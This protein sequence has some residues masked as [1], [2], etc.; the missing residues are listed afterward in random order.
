MSTMCK[1]PSQSTYNILIITGNAAAKAMEPELAEL[2]QL[3][4]HQREA[5]GL[6]G[7]EQQTTNELSIVMGNEKL[8]RD[9]KAHTETTKTKAKRAEQLQTK[10]CVDMTIDE[11][12]KR[13]KDITVRRKIKE[14]Q[15]RIE[16]MVSS[17]NQRKL[18]INNMS[19]NFVML[20]K[21]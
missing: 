17:I 6:K 9:V 4:Q 18:I 15:G 11:A 7:Y 19:G 8:L 1:T 2:F 14:V 16:M 10:L 21:Q 5:E 12:F 3:L 13:G 20:S